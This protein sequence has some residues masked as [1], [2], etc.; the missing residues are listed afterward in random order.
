MKHSRRSFLG[1][2]WARKTVSW[3]L[4]VSML[5]TVL[6]ME[7]FAADLIERTLQTV[8]GETSTVDE[9]SVVDE[10][11]AATEQ[12]GEEVSE[13]TELGSAVSS[14]AE[15]EETQL[16][17]TSKSESSAIPEETSVPES[18]IESKDGSMDESAAES[19]QEL[20]A[21]S[22]A[23]Q[24]FLVQMDALPTA[25]EIYEST[26]ADSDPAF[27]EWYSN[28]Q[29]TLAKIEAA[30]TTY[31]A[32]TAEEKLLVDEAYTVK[33]N[34]L[35]A[36][37]ASLALIRPMDASTST[38]E[39]CVDGGTPK[40]TDSFVIA[41][42]ELDSATNASTS[43]VKLLK[44]D[45]VTDSIDIMGGKFTLNLNGHVMTLSNTMLLQF[46][47]THVIITD[48]SFGGKITSSTATT[49]VGHVNGAQLTLNGGT[50]ENTCPDPQNKSVVR[51]QFNNANDGGKLTINGGT[52]SATDSFGNGNA[53]YASDEFL[54]TGGTIES[55]SG[56]VTL[57]LSGDAVITGGTIKNTGGVSAAIVGTASG[58]VK[59]SGGTFTGIG[60][61]ENCYA[62]K[63]YGNVE[64]SGSPVLSGQTSTVYLK[65]GTSLRANIDGSF[66]TGGA[67]SIF[68]L[69]ESQTTGTIL[70]EGLE[71]A[72]Q[73]GKFSLSNPKSGLASV[74]ES[75]S[76][77]LR[78]LHYVAEVTVDSTTTQY[79]TIEE[80]WTAATKE[81]SA[82]IKL[83]ESSTFAT[84]LKKTTSGN[85]TITLD[86]NGKTMTY[87]GTSS[88]A[89]TVSSLLELNIKD[90]SSGKTGSIIGGA[91]TQN[92]IYNSGT[93]SIAEATI[94]AAAG[95]SALYSAATPNVGSAGVTINSGTLKAAASDNGPAVVVNNSGSMATFEVT[96]GN[97]TGGGKSAVSNEG[98]GTLSIQ[99]GVISGGKQY[100]VYNAGAG[101]LTIDGG[102]ITGDSKWAVIGAAS[103]S[104]GKIVIGGSA[105]II[106]TKCLGTLE[107]GGADSSLTIS[108]GSISSTGRSLS[109]T[110]GYMIYNTRAATVKVTDGTLNAENTTA[111]LLNGAAGNVTI[112]GGK[113]SY[114]GSYALVLN[115]STG[116]VSVSGGEFS[117]PRIIQ[118][119]DTGT[120]EISGG[121]LTGSM[122]AVMNLKTGLIKISGAPVISGSI[123][124]NVPI[125]GKNFTGT[126]PCSISWGGTEAANT[127]V[128]QDH[129][130]P[131]FTLTDYNWTLAPVAGNLVL[132]KSVATVTPQG[133][134]IKGYASFDAAWKA[135]AG[136]Y[137]AATIKLLDHIQSEK[138][139]TLMNG[140]ANLT[141][142]LNGKTLEDAKKNET[143]LCMNQED[144]NKNVSLTV[145][146]SSIGGRL[147]GASSEALIMVDDNASLTIASGIVENQQT[148]SAVQYRS[149]MPM[150]ITG[151]VITNTGDGHAIHNYSNSKITINGGQVTT[152]S[153]DK[154]KSA[155][156][157]LGGIAGEDILEIKSGKVENTGAGSAVSNLDVGT[158]KIS[159]GQVLSK[160]SPAVSCAYQ[161]SF[162][163]SSL[164]ISGGT[165]TSENSSAVQFRSSG[166]LTVSGGDISGKTYGITYSGTGARTLSGTPVISGESAGLQVNN[167]FDATSYTGVPV[168]VEWSQTLTDSSA[169][170]VVVTGNTDANTF[171]LVNKG[172]KI[173]PDASDQN[174]MLEKKGPLVYIGET[175][176]ESMKE[177]LEAAAT[178]GG[179]VAIVIKEPVKVD[180]PLFV[181]GNG[182]ITLDMQDTGSITYTGAAN[183]A[184]FTV[185]GSTDLT[186]TGPGSLAGGSGS[187]VVNNGTGTVTVDGEV[188]VTAEGDPVLKNTADGQMTVGAGAT[189]NAGSNTAI[190]NSGSGTVT[191]E[192]IVSGNGSPVMSNT[193]DGSIVVSGSGKV[194]GVDVTA[195]QNSGTGSLEI[196]G[197]TVNGGSAD[198]PAVENTSAGKVTVTG[199]ATIENINGT[200]ITNS[201]AGEVI[202]SGGTVSGG[203]V[204]KPVINNMGDGELI[205]NNGS[206]MAG[207]STAVENSSTGNVT[208]S[209][210][211]VSGDADQVVKNSDGGTILVK[212]PAVINGSGNTVIHNPVGGTVTIEG[213]SVSNNGTGS[214]VSN[215]G[216]LY[217]NGGNLETKGKDA[218]DN[219]GGT[220]HLGNST[221]LGDQT[222]ST[223]VPFDGGNFGGD[224]LQINWT[225]SDKA[226]G[227]IV[228]TGSSDTGKFTV[229][230][231]GYQLKAE[232]GNLVLEAVSYTIQYDLAGGA[233]ESNPV[234]YTIESAAITLHNPVKSGWIF[235]GW[236]GTGL[237]GGENMTVIIP[238]ASIGNRLYTA[239][240]QSDGTSSEIP[241]PPESSD[242]EE[243]SATSTPSESSDVNESSK[244]PDSSESSGVDESSKEPDS[245]ESSDMSES[246]AASDLPAT[247]DGSALSLMGV[248]L[249]VSAGAI[250]LML[251]R[252]KKTN[253]E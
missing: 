126:T 172:W 32:F 77:V 24:D 253:K 129:T 166:S 45:S 11:S 217:V 93:V 134:E 53:V 220:I 52:I 81:S 6:P 152:S 96:G 132:V 205:I 14:A 30:E 143:F 141:L 181:T 80:A 17:K 18:A 133:G 199:Q 44:D 171:S 5:Y 79:E 228:V 22:A 116:T 76:L 107:P 92:V 195:I 91:A 165:L 121:K 108:G 163:N 89:I 74:Y 50:I 75:N 248:L 146:S 15:Q 216:T 225:K 35:I 157:S 31:M 68:Y 85:G 125:S 162:P 78:E 64:L 103:T 55:A 234:S 37:V 229:V 58:V 150:G 145:K 244:E 179:N 241:D 242:V 99:G 34:N 210:G 186:I 112:S 153:A 135:A 130:L 137:Q 213:G 25:E 8:Q 41:K 36:L 69:A 118:N 27:A 40:Y 174:L 212:S 243:S 138:I 49:T 156:H 194:I 151:G 109:Y 154:S 84:E 139:G 223:D 180:T 66:Y 117:G 215:N 237:T 113:L 67:V 3:V 159:G 209:G 160:D 198:K 51:S 182:H 245:S 29:D 231:E 100:T 7:T 38:Y 185:E 124:T 136:E 206:I 119:K 1:K 97:I 188:S 12:D 200:T 47:A 176:Y 95:C 56:G 211:T 177:A 102:T 39:Y 247:G 158:V 218:V 161:D 19:V 101:K 61:D 115:E 155:I 173:V 221:S 122:N 183:E 169:G 252:R 23:L 219:Q 60:A 233:V 204:D 207:N 246:G 10:P 250:F 120:V 189:V 236:S 240:W 59:V 251:Y 46:D 57:A 191:I 33:L 94:S 201:G 144:S 238:G 70:V 104:K 178:I 110:Y 167:A 131:K 148:G 13:S 43:Y 26:P 203:T 175:E 227:D 224:N 222:I 90:N 168:K 184:L 239:N 202:I 98:Y 197:G 232:A 142:D 20:A 123:V 111:L 128:V 63:N 72:T 54:M 140:R 235:T 170:N 106:G 208:I 230:N 2:R 164:E 86:L 4:A 9:K 105:N 65:S 127:I 28:L 196:S 42:R 149:G 87:T 114:S 73:A 21:P 249:L 226:S 16:E 48:S 187:A 214:C 62:I 71:N 82:T 147:L 192:G 88:N 83:L 193:N 190:I